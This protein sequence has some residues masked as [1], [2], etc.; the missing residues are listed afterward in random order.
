M[1]SKSVPKGRR[2]RL[3]AE[4]Q[5]RCETFQQRS[6]VEA[7]KNSKGSSIDVRINSERSSSNS[8]ERFDEQ[9]GA[10]S[11]NSP[12]NNRDDAFMFDDYLINHQIQNPRP[13]WARQRYI[14]T[15]EGLHNEILDY[16][17]WL[18]PTAEEIACRRRL[19]NNI[20][21][22]LMR[23]WPK[24]QV[25]MFGSVATNSFLP[26]SDIDICVLTGDRLSIPDDLNKVADIL[27]STP[28]FENIIVLD[29]TAIPIVKCAHTTTQL[30]VDINF[31]L[32]HVSETVNWVQ[33][34]I[35]DIRQL[36]PLLLV[37]KQFLA[38]R[39][40][41]NPFEGGLPSYALVVM[42]VYFLEIV[43]LSNKRD[44]IQKAHFNS[45]TANGKKQLGLLLHYFLYYFG[46]SFDYAHCGINM[47]S[48]KGIVSKE[49]LALQL[50]E[51][52]YTSGLWICDPV[53]KDN[54]LGKGAHNIL[55]IKQA[56]ADAYATILTAIDYCNF[57][58]NEFKR[59]FYYGPMLSL[60]IDS[61][62]MMVHREENIVNSRAWLLK[63]T[64]ETTTE[65]PNNQ[66]N[67]RVGD[68]NQINDENAKDAA[69]NNKKNNKVKHL[70]KNR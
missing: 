32:T 44:P 66:K 55:S 26:S 33:E 14:P 30:R 51:S 38:Q 27:R 12:H 59:R 1:V 42:L 54:N 24:A 18:K 58:P 13:S 61:S 50:S 9:E 37:L 60:V 17:Q 22:I 3:L 20:S 21:F 11:S 67:V 45:M 34:K 6:Y 69:I 7:H 5:P 62:G 8:T 28:D 39:R 29:K 53:K 2:M 40:L 64:I 49:K 15:I 68:N 65:K 57:L 47:D 41:N 23:I 35:N 19:F 56:F 10:T 70:K 63:H 46:C 48:R 36:E 4:Q 43:R 16:Y 52:L 31:N 25:Q